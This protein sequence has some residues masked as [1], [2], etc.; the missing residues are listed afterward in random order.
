MSG[1]SGPVACAKWIL[2]GI[3]AAAAVMGT[4]AVRGGRRPPAPLPSVGR[5]S[6]P[7]VPAEADPAGSRGTG[8]GGAGSRGTGS[9]GTGSG[10]A[11]S[12]GADTSPVDRSDPLSV[13]SVVAVALYRSECRVART[14][15]LAPLLSSHGAEVVDDVAP[16]LV[17]PGLL[18][19]AA[20]AS[21]RLV[22]PRAAPVTVE[23]AVVRWLSGA[24]GVGPARA[25]PV[26]HLVLLTMM[27]G[28]GA[29]TVDD[30]AVVA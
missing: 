25:D 27:P 26:R 12:G 30:L 11:G 19:T 17:A 13:A 22:E 14:Q 20:A 16:T 29:W 15:R 28:D 21:A 9:G 8:S 5:R 2:L 18:S 4:L 23:V 10:G 7:P 1:S 24:G 6:A 3:A